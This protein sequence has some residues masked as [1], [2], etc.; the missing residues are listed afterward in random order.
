MKADY[1]ADVYYFDY[2]SDA[3][4][5]V[6]L[7]EK[8]KKGYD[9]VVIGVHNYTRYPANNFGISIQAVQLI[10]QI[11]QDTKSLILFFGNPYAI[12][13]VCNTGNVVACYEDDEIFQNAALDILEGKQ[14]AKGKLPV[15]VCEKFPFGTGVIRRTELSFEKPSNLGF[16]EAKL[17][18]IDSLANDAIRKHATPGCV[19]L[20][21]KDGKIAYQKSFG[22]YTYDS[23]ELV[24]NESIFDM[25]SCTKIFA[26][27][28]AVMKLRDEGKLDIDKKLGDYLGWVKGTNKEHLPFKEILLHQAGL[29]AFIPF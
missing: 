3:G 10:N 24:N 14:Q 9:A 26:T 5:K 23:T 4:R 20:V 12:R 6:S 22:Y 29:I 13:N 18:Q 27:T 2:K 16:D 1:N 25:A 28:L 19:V 21:A 7:M 17:N 11:Q 15:T 8:L